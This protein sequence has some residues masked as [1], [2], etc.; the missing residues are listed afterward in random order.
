MAVVCTP[1][2]SLPLHYDASFKVDVRLHEPL[3]TRDITPIDTEIE[4][5]SLCSQLDI[6]CHKEL[7]EQPKEKIE[8]GRFSNSFTNRAAVVQDRM[9]QVLHKN[10]QNRMFVNEYLAAKGL[11]R[12]FPRA[13]AFISSPVNLVYLNDKTSLDAYYADISSLNQLKY[14]AHQINSDLSNLS[15]HKYVAHQISILYQSVNN[16]NNSYLDPYK[17]SIEENFKSVKTTLNEEH[18]DGTRKLLPEQK[19]WLLQLTSGIANLISRFPIE[20]TQE[21]VQPALVLQ[22]QS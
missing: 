21:M 18:K 11:D 3:L 6:L 14:L 10:V 17:K 20:L 13:S 1:P 22:Q 5:M 12:L 16:I 15:E 19:E 4:M 9:N 7:K 8:Q 2:L